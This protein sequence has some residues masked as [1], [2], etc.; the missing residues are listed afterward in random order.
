MK[1]WTWFSGKKTVIGTA[2][3]MVAAFFVQT[4]VGGDAAWAD[5]LIQAFDYIGLAMGGVGLGHKAVK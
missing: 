2:F 1:L 5:K 3:L 4:D